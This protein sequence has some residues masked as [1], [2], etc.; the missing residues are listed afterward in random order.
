MKVTNKTIRPIGFVT[1]EL[2]EVELQ[3]IVDT[4]EQ[5]QCLLQ[6]TEIMGIRGELYKEFK[7]LLKTN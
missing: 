3:S 7:S 2:N 5:I 4:M 1:I 6:Q